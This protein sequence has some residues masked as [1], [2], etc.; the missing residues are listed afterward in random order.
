LYT[1]VLLHKYF[2]K[3][4]GTA[5]PQNVTS[6]RNSAIAD[7][8]GKVEYYGPLIPIGMVHFVQNWM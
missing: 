2:F 1:L 4:I 3:K 6:F 5:V 8:T 7:I